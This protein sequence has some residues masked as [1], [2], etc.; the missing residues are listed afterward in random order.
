MDRNA[1]FSP[2]A[3]TQHYIVIALSMNSDTFNPVLK[4]ERRLELDN[5]KTLILVKRVV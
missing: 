3:G 5:M 4:E 2:L 1:V